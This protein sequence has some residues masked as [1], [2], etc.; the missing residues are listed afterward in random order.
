MY[1]LKQKVFFKEIIRNKVLYLMTLPGLLFILVVYY[2]PMLGVTIAF[3]EYNP[4][5]GVLGS[6]W[7]GFKNFEF[8]FRTGAILTA[9]FNTIFYN[10]IFMITG[11]GFAMMAAILLNETGSHILTSTYKS[12]MLFP[13]LLSWVVAEYLLYGF[14]SIDKGL[15]NNILGVLGKES[16]DW[17]SEPLYWRFFI[18]L[19]YLWKQIGY[20]SVIFV[21]GI[22]GISPECYEAAEIE[23]A[24]KLQQA[25]RITIPM[26]MPITIILVLLQAGKFFYAGFGDW[27]VFFNLPRE[28]GML[29]SATDVID[30][31]VFR[32]LRMMGDFGM[33]SAASFY[34]SCVGFVLVLLSNHVIRKYDRESSLF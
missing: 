20:Q 10:L 15:I 6:Q 11:I 14:L 12:V 5:K 4:I 31:Y 30:T 18:P 25:L 8:L 13:Y 17:Y 33:S 23:G 28:S 2:L 7:N 16:V 21:A 19:G 24:T 29:F 22:S 3:Q 27:G 9:T 32:S 1:A 26:I 34:Q